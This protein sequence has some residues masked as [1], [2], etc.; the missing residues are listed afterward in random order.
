M[1]GE[2]HCIPGNGNQVSEDVCNLLQHA[3][4]LRNYHEIHH[5]DQIQEILHRWPLLGLTAEKAVVSPAATSSPGE[6]ANVVLVTGAAGGVGT[7]TVVA[8]LASALRQQGEQVLAVDLSPGQ[9]LHLHPGEH[10][11][12]T[13]TGDRKRMVEALSAQDGHVSLQDEDRHPNW[14]AARLPAQL[15]NSYGWIL[16]DCPWSAQTTFHQA[17]SIAHQ[18]LLVCTTEPA[19]FSRTS[20]ALADPASALESGADRLHLLINRF[21]PAH[22][23]QRDIHTLLR[24]NSPANLAP[25]EI[26]YDSRIADSMALGRSFLSLDP[27]CEAAR[28]FHSLG[29]W[30]AS[31]AAQRRAAAP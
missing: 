17:C 23:L 6:G 21:N 30:L 16:I 1:N 25:A 14:L 31:Q 28:C 12:E 2:N 19:A 26:P 24:S 10:G 15:P 27:D 29:Y 4:N 11:G 5:H 3:P 18:V 20:R 22:L 13:E 8:N 9:D 7:T